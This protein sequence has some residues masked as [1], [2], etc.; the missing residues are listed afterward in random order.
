MVFWART[1]ASIFGFREAA[2]RGSLMVNRLVSGMLVAAWKC[3]GVA[4]TRALSGL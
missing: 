2:V 1:I 3:L 4:P